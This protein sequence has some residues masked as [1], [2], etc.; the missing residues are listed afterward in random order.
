MAVR[1]DEGAEVLPFRETRCICKS[2]IKG[3]LSPF[4]KMLVDVCI[5]LVYCVLRRVAPYIL[6]S[7]LCSGTGGDSFFLEIDVSMLSVS[8]ACFNL[9][10][11]NAGRQAVQH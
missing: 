4:E 7:V 3:M 10:S 11:T 1:E 5:R 6:D 8:K 2:D 9:Q